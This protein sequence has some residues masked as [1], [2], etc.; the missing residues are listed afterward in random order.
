MATGNFE[1]VGITGVPVVAGSLTGSSNSH[2]QLKSVRILSD[3]AW[4]GPNTN[5]T[6]EECIIDGSPTLMPSGFVSTY[7]TV[8]VSAA[9]YRAHP[10]F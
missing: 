2:L 9:H 1:V 3:F 5:L 6:I 4:D 8:S 10:L 7:R